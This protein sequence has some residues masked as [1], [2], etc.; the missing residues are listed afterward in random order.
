MKSYQA[1]LNSHVNTVTLT[2]KNA[3]KSFIRRLRGGH[4]VFRENNQKNQ[5]EGQMYW[6]Q[7]AQSYQARH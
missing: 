5:E 3:N 2:E 1:S 6:V 4:K 7:D